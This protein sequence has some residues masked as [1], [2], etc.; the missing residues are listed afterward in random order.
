MSSASPAC[1]STRCPTS[2][3]WRSG[4]SSRR[5]TWPVRQDGFVCGLISMNGDLISK[6]S[7]EHLLF[8][9]VPATAAA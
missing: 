8:G 6:V 7:V 1:W 4:T 3:P 9:T 2:S 5:R